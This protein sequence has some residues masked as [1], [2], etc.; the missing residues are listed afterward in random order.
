MNEKIFKA[1]ETVSVPEIIP[2]NLPVVEPDFAQGSVMVKKGE[3]AHDIAHIE[4]TTNNL[5][6][7]TDNIKPEKPKM[8]VPD[9]RYPN[10]KDPYREPLV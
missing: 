6:P 10:G 3:V 8:P 7:T 1:I 2:P 4:P 9:Y 5:Q